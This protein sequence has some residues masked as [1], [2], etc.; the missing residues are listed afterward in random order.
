MFPE[1][2]YKE[3]HITIESK[4]IFLKFKKWSIKKMYELTSLIFTWKTL[5]NK[6]E[7]SFGFGLDFYSVSSCLTDI[8]QSGIRVKTR[9]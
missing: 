5:C 8:F 9:L 4:I 3:R 1:V 7:L 6:K 2:M